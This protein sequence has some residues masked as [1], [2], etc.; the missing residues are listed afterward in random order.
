MLVE[1]AVKANPV[2]AGDYVGDNGLLYCG[3]CH[4][5]KQSRIELP[6]FLKKS[7]CKDIVPV[8][9]ECQKAEDEYLNELK[10]KKREEADIRRCKCFADNEMA[11]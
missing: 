3:K 10:M 6:E 11:E 5:L 8:E 4:T 7:G 2:Q 9:C 1:N